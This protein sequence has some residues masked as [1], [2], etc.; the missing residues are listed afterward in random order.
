MVIRALEDLIGMHYHV[1]IFIC[2]WI[3]WGPPICTTIWWEIS[4]GYKWRLVL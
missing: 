3:I 4:N 1:N 2:Q